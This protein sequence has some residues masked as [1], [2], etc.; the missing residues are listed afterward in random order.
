[1]YDGRKWEMQRPPFDMGNAPDTF[2]GFGEFR[3]DGGSLL[4]VDREGVRLTFT[5]DDGVEPACM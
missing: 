3:L 2:S 1:M 4:F 5:L